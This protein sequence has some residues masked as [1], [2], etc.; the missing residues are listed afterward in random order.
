[1]A[2]RFKVRPAPLVTGE[3]PL[4]VMEPPA[5]RVVLANVCTEAV[6]PG[7]DVKVTLVLLA[8]A[9]ALAVRVRIA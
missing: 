9:V 1:M 6:E 5:A 2:P 3:T 4:V 7:V 8:V